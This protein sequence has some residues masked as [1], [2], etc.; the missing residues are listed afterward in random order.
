[1]MT[2][3]VDSARGRVA[4]AR[5]T[6]A[7][8]ERPRPLHDLH[9]VGAAASVA[10][11]GY[12]ALCVLATGVGLFVTHV[13]AQGVVGRGDTEIARWL[14]D[15]RTPTL[16]DLSLVGS[17]LAETVTVLSI[18][19]VV[20]V[21][22]AIRR[23]WPLVALVATSLAL[24]ATTYL[25]VTFAVS[26]NRP[27]VPR[28]E[29]LVVSDSFPSGHTAASVALY[30]CLAIVV[31]AETRRRLW[32]VTALVAAV[33]VPVVVATSRV[34]RGMHYP[35]DTISGALVGAACIAIAYVAVRRAIAVAESRS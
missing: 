21:T 13:L 14:A 32:R 20:I 29:N 8:V 35:T 25:A 24:E 33:L 2:G 3:G 5:P 27:P 22:L 34:Y 28:F 18:L 6:A 26:R 9:P 12:V 7:A 15:H 11:G 31:C 23:A 30:G 10:V 1:M 16:D 19:L 17:Y 4:G